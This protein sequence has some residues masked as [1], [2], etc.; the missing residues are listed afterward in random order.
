MLIAML[1][2]G[3]VTTVPASGCG[4]ARSQQKNLKKY[5]RQHKHHR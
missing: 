4:Y 3:C 2:T 1:M 5:H